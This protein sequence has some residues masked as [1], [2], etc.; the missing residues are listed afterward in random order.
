MLM[1]QSKI[2]ED[3]V[4]RGTQQGSNTTFPVVTPTKQCYYDNNKAY[5]FRTAEQEALN[6][7]ST[8][9]IFDRVSCSASQATNSHRS[10]TSMDHVPSLRINEVAA[11]ALSSFGDSA[12]L[13]QLLATLGQ[14]QSCDDKANHLST[15]HN[16]YASTSSTYDHIAQPTSTLELKGNERVQE[17]YSGHSVP[18]YYQPDKSMNAVVPCPAMT[19]CPSSR[20]RSSMI[21]SSRR[22][23]MIP[24][25][26][27]RSSVIPSSRR[28]S[29]G[30]SFDDIETILNIDLNNNTPKNDSGN[31]TI[32]IPYQRVDEQNRDTRN[33]NT[34]FDLR[35]SSSSSFTSPN[36]NGISITD[37]IDPLDSE[38]P[39]F[40]IKFA[41][42][43]QRRLK[44]LVNRMGQTSLSR[45]GL[46]ELRLQMAKENGQ[47]FHQDDII[48]TKSVRKS[49]VKPKRK[50]CIPTKSNRKTMEKN[51]RRSLSL[52]FCTPEMIF[53]C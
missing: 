26:R 47:I 11:D 31:G 6:C 16:P 44:I 50:V 7:V 21:P 41:E 22:S 43:Y 36:H 42:E 18:S 33:H 4:N 1:K 9:K 51:H 38:S 17:D 28:S 53:G 2:N 35:P 46:E 37:A 30:V 40:S 27:R 10:S 34:S 14:N 8:N 52:K 12:Y 25:S 13:L 24:S 15:P 19:V 5:D 32:P 39:C 29:L 3:H 48:E 49:P 20:R 23:S 45:Q